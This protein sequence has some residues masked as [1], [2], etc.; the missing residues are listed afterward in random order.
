MRTKVLLILALALITLGAKPSSIKAAENPLLQEADQLWQEKSYTLA[1]AKYEE[2]LKSP[3]LSEI[4][5][6][7]V[8]FKLADCQWRSKEEALYPGATKALL[9]LIESKDHNRWW[10]ESNES[11]A[12]C[13]LEKDRWSHTNEIKQYLESARDFWAGSSDVKTARKRYIK[14]SFTL[15]DFVSQNWGWYANVI[16]PVGIVKEGIAP[17]PQP[18]A[19]S[20]LYK[21]ILKIAD[22]DLDKA[23][24]TYSLAMCSMNNYSDQK[25]TKLAEKYFKEI[26]D[27]YSTSEWVDDSYYQLAQYY[28]RQNDFVKALET[29]RGLVVHFRLGDSQWVNEAEN[30]I[31]DISSPALRVGVGYSFLPDSEIQFSLGWRNIKEAQF[32]FYKLDLVEALQFNQSK[33]PTDSSYGVEYYSSLFQNMVDSRRYASLPVALTFQRAL[34]DEG[35][36]QWSDENKGL[37]EWQLTDD[38]NEVD[39]KKGILPTG[40]YILVV[41]SG[42]TKAYEMVMV[43]D[44]GLV[45]K[46]SG[47]AA[48]FFTFD[49]KSGKPRANT[50]IKGQY[51]YYDET[52]NWSWDEIQ[53]ITDDLGL[54][55]AT[56]K[57]STNRRHWARS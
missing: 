3:G 1:A 14:V 56:L 30:R 53:G 33:S 50:K 2:I 16:T 27:K 19:L 4:T 44:L 54:L 11:L 25:E 46:V 26:I 49:S 36:H 47:H 8:K 34:K 17:Q 31:K 10:A 35:K 55:K 23:K 43:T 18:Q 39:I 21:E 45:S 48:L 42:E 5:T 29:Y 6:Q 28:E 51:R 7:E 32:T 20:D 15:G 24:A 13:Y 12:E 22:N 37:A 57:T 38:K 41:S 9:E 52:G 40:T